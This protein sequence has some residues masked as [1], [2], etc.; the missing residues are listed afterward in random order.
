MSLKQLLQNYAY[1]TKKELESTP[2]E[3]LGKIEFLE[4][5]LQRIKYELDLLKENKK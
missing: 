1:K 3:L 5:E 4:E 2:K